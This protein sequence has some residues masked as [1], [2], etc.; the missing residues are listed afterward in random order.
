MIFKSDSG[1]QETRFV[2]AVFH[3]IGTAYGFGVYFARDA[4]YSFGYAGGAGGGGAMY[5]ARVLVGDYCQGRPKIL[6]PDPKDQNKVTILY[7]SV[8]DNTSIPTIF[9]VFNDAQC[10]PEYIIWF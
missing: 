10:Y 1:L 6:Q 5:L 9:V 2:V 4:S 7:D 3:V 8:V